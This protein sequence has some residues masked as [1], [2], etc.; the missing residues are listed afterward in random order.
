MASGMRTLLFSYGLSSGRGAGPS[1]PSPPRF[2][3][4]ASWNVPPIHNSEDS[5]HESISMALLEMSSIVAHR[6]KLA[7]GYVIFNLFTP[8]VF[9]SH[10]AVEAGRLGMAMTVLRR[11]HHSRFKLDQRQGAQLHHAHLSWRTGRSN[12]LSN[13]GGAR[14]IIAHRA[15]Q[16]VIV[17]LVVRG[18][19]LRHPL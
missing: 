19:A 9:A 14:S 11:H 18:N 15:A 7:C 10:G 5:Q 12:R 4:Q 17:A 2:A 3:P 16:F 8:I 1:A 6:D 13:R